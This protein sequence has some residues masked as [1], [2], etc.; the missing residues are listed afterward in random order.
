M[1]DQQRATILDSTSRFPIHQG[2]KLSYGTAGFRADGSI[3]SSTV[4]RVGILAALRSLKTKS[5]IGLMITASHN[6]VSDNGVKIADPSGGMLTQEWEPFA[7]KLAN[8]GSAEELVRV[9]LSEVVKSMESDIQF[10]S[11]KCYKELLICEFTKE[12]NI[13]FEGKHHAEVLLARDTRPSGE[14]L[15]EAAKQGI[16]SIVGAIA[17]NMGILTTPQLHWMVRCRNKGHMVSEP[18]YF[19]Q[20]SNSFR[21]L[22]DLIPK[23]N[24]TYVMDEHLIVDGANGVGGEKLVELKKMLSG[25]VI[26]VRNSGKKGEG[27]LNEGVGADFVQKEKVI[28]HGFDSNDLGIRLVIYSRVFIFTILFTWLI[29][30]TK[31]PVKLDK[32]S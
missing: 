26:E 23:D 30:K 29:E 24:T 1:N 20:L 32:A 18:A 27:V 28:P 11:S 16:N 4:F 3:L 7:D 17:T 5:V 6:Q 9:S 13:S 12:E 21:C 10:Q 22:M 25:L 15:L 2:V 31:G 8:A 19:D 14:Y